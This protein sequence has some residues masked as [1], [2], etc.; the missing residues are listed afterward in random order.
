MPRK[1]GRWKQPK[2]EKLVKSNGALKPK[3]VSAKKATAAKQL[4]LPLALPR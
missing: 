1:P 4:T 2:A 3:K